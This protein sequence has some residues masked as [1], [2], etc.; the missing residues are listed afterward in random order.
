MNKKKLIGFRVFVCFLVLAMTLTVFASCSGSKGKTLMS[1]ES[2]TISVNVYQLLLS[3]MKGAL[4]RSFG[5][6]VM[7]DSFWQT[8]IESDGTT[9]NDY[10]TAEV[11][12]NTKTYLVALYL[13]DHYGLE[14]SEDVIAKVDEEMEGL[15]VGDGDGSKS[16]LNQILSAYGMNYN[17]LRDFYLMEK[18][19]AALQ[20]HL[21]GTDAS[22]VASG[23][24]NEFMR[25]N[26]VCFRQIF[27][28]S[29]YYVK[30]VDAY[31]NV[32][33]FTSDGSEYLYDTKN[34]VTMEDKNGKTIVDKFGNEVYFDE[35]GKVL[36]DTKKGKTL[37]VTD[38]DGAYTTKDY[39]KEELEKIE[40]NAELLAS[41]VTDGD[42]EDFE[43][44]MEEYSEDEEGMEEYENGY[45]LAKDTTYSYT[46]LNDICAALAEMKVGESKLI[47]SDYGYHLIMKYECED[48]A[49]AE[50]AN[51]IW[52]SDFNSMLIEMLFLQEAEKYM[53]GI[54]LDEDLLG[55]LDMKSVTH[56]Y[57][58]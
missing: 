45:F 58:Y 35:E 6:Q 20:N 40:K 29:Y 10:F 38:E 25:E 18:K 47:T 44:L 53:D 37:Y 16:Q 42:F 5:S 41:Q 51:K 21:Y 46:Y 48:G 14:L 43:D 39:S 50:D 26:Y 28:A 30:E 36:Y 55:T 54:K 8:T 34:G 24:K 23:V 12:H 15:L 49:Y 22:L 52:F 32:A 33:Y 2:A 3:R 19:V 7:T 27:L 31:G 57:Y 17:L 13:F 4:A 1:L 9:Y 11:L 56:N